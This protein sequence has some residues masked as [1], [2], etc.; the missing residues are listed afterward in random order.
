[1]LPSEYP[2]RLTEA[3]RSPRGPEPHRAAGSPVCQGVSGAGRQGEE[4]SQRA[5]MALHRETHATGVTQPLP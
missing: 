1:M 3:I 2:A 4:S 5:G